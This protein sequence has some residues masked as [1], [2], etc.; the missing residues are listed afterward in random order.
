MFYMGE[1]PNDKKPVGLS[2]GFNPRDRPMFSMGENP[3]DKPPMMFHM[4]ENPN[5]RPPMFSMGGPPMFSMG[6]PMG[7]G[8]P[9]IPGP[10]NV[11]TDE[12]FV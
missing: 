3:N 12:A 7:G 2:M 8:P 5:D 11:N 9:P 4:G 6:G 10:K 1:N